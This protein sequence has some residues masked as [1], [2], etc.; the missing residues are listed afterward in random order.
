[1]KEQGVITEDKAQILIL[2]PSALK[3]LRDTP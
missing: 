2:S 3:R 1:M